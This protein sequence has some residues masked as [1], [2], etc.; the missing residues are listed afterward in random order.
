MLEFENIAFLDQQKTGTTTILKAL[1]VLLDEEEIHLDRHGP[2]P[3]GFDRRK[4]CF[5]SVRDPLSLYISLFKFG[6]TSKKGTLFKFLQKRQLSH[7]YEPTLEAFEPWLRFVLDPDNAASLGSRYARSNQADRI[8]MLTFRVLYLSIPKLRSRIAECDSGKALEQM[9]ERERIYS[10]YVRTECLYDD[11]FGVLRHWKSGIK[12]KSSLTTVEDMIAEVK[13]LNVSGK[14]E[15]LSADNLSPELRE[16]VHK[17]EWLLYK[18]F[19]YDKNPLGAP[20]ACLAN[21]E[22]PASQR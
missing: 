21:G 18:T 9:F 17:R 4:K 16:L 19:G 13:T 7:Y 3:R 22:H 6:A 5:V 8:G 12:L 2:V 1:R 11:L 10:E 14:I 20:T 15:R